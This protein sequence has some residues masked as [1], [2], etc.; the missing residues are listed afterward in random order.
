MTDKNAKVQHSFEKRGE[1][2]RIVFRNGT[3]ILVAMK[4]PDKEDKDFENVVILNR[5][6]TIDE[7]DLMNALMGLLTRT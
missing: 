5:I 1:N 7:S 6:K 3:P 4:C 2:D